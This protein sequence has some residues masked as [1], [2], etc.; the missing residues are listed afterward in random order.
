MSSSRPRS[1]VQQCLK[2][3]LLDETTSTW[4]PSC[5]VLV[6]GVRASRH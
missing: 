6:S 2:L 1:L 3:G 4:Y 5:W